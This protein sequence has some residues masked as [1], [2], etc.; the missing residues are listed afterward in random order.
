MVRKPLIL[1]V[2]MPVTCVVDGA[3]EQN[4]KFPNQK[5]YPV[6]VNGEEFLL[7]ASDTMHQKL[8]KMG[9][10][11]GTTFQIKKEDL[12][13]GYQINKIFDS[14]GKE[15]ELDRNNYSGNKGS[16]RKKD[17][18]PNDVASIIAQWAIGQANYGLYLYKQAGNQISDNPDKTILD[19]A[20]KYYAF[21]RTIQAEILPDVISD[22]KEDSNS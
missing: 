3:P 18:S 14:T 6:K 22:M 10:T 11:F 19:M 20:R 2:N 5:R 21:K 15:V 1:S 16:S 7:N 17:R 13:N 12:P 4:E 8:Q 9:A